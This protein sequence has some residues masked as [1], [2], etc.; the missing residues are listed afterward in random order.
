MQHCR[1]SGDLS[2]LADGRTRLTQRIVLKGAK[3]DIYLLQVK[4]AF[5]ANL[6]TE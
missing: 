1:L 5:T 6:L 3:A 2:G 4:V